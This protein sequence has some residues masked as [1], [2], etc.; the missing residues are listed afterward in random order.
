MSS[1]IQANGSAHS[2]VIRVTIASSQPCSMHSTWIDSPGHIVVVNEQ[3]GCLTDSNDSPQLIM[4]LLTASC[5]I[6][7]H[8]KIILTITGHAAESFDAFESF[9]LRLYR[10]PGPV[11]H[12]NIPA[13]QQN[14]S[15]AGNMT[16]DTAQSPGADAAN[17]TLSAAGVLPVAEAK[18]TQADPA[19]PKS[20]S[21]WSRLCALAEHVAQGL[22]LLR[23]RASPHKPSNASASIPKP[24]LSNTS[25]ANHPGNRTLGRH[26]LQAGTG[27]ALDTCIAHAVDNSRTAVL[28]REQWS[29]RRHGTCSFCPL[30]AMNSTGAK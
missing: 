19:A 4:R 14:S 26:L 15:A 24:V 16:L 21:F 7:A 6:A 27:D 25:V 9:S 23:L 17:A 2:T 30:R 5:S 20:S 13:W 22:Q 29:E 12:I 8:G 28:N 10:G 1:H 11:P 18:K 3:E